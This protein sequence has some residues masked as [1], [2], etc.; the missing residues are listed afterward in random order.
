VVSVAQLLWSIALVPQRSLRASAAMPISPREP[1]P[2][3]SRSSK[4]HAKARSC[5]SRPTKVPSRAATVELVI[6]LK[7]AKALGVTIPPPVLAR[8]ERL[9]E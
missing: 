5:S 3:W 9:P 1:S 7:T 6:N 2:I 8:A 4:R